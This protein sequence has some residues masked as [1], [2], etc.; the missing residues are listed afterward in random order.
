M[1]T[2]LAVAGDSNARA[3][4][5]AGRHV[6][7]KPRLRFLAP[8]AAARFARMRDHVPFAAAARTGRLRDDLA[9][10]R[11]PRAAQSS[12]AAAPLARH[13]H[14]SG[15]STAAVAA[16]AL[17]EPVEDDLFGRSGKRLFERNLD[18][19]AKIR[20]ALRSR[21]AASAL[22]RE[23]CRRT[24]RRCRR[25]RPVRIQSLHRRRR[26]CRRR[27]NDRTARVCSDRRAPRRPR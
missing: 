14:R 22:H 7:G 9:E 23:R 24:C 2:G 12:A 6:D 20:A 8:A 27:R 3:V 21:C 26:R 17:R 11:L 25:S 18:V 5:D 15:L 13:D 19:V 10:R 4:V 1:R 16:L